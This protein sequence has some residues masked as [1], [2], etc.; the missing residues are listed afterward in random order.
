MSAASKRPRRPEPNQ[1]LP[2]R[3]RALACDVYIPTKKQKAPQAKQT[4]PLVYA[5]TLL[6]RPLPALAVPTPKAA[7]KDNGAHTT[8]KERSPADPTTQF[9]LRKIHAHYGLRRNKRSY[10]ERMMKCFVRPR[11]P[12]LMASF[13]T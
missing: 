5:P 8:R 11:R 10:L 4:E 2:K 7:S 9:S 1:Q 13:L 6:Q 3:I 12:P